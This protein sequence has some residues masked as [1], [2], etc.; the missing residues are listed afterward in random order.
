MQKLK[1]VDGKSEFTETYHTYEEV[2][3]ICA[4][5]NY[6]VGYNSAQQSHLTFI[7]I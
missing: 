7:S 1:N 5:K 3:S 2:F 6:M 4:N